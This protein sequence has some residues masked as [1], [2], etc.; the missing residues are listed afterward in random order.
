MNTS[1][2]T[3]SKGGERQ[4]D[5][6]IIKSFATRSEM[7]AFA[8]AEIAQDLRARLDRQERVRMVFA[9]A[10]SQRDVLDALARS[11]GVDWTRVEAFHMDEYVGL[12]ED[13][14]QRFGNWLGRHFFDLVPLAKVHRMM[15]GN[16][17]AATAREY[18]DLLSAAPIDVIQL[19]IGVN[20]HVAFNDPP[21]ARFDD[22]EKVKIV[23]LDNVC[24]QQQV[25]DDCFERFEDV[26]ARAITLT[27][28]C[29]MSAERLFC[30]VPG[31][32]KRAAVK[33]ALEGPITTACPAS[34]LRQHPACTLYLDQDSDPH[35]R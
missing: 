17:P 31:Q 7:G 30:M 11:E 20:G 18:A 16:D 13:A 27:V 24:R 3:S 26:P 35:A 34:I 12:A 5:K 32:T 15:P 22:P 25:D 23:E 29:L 21:V 1:A 8:A 6:L 2:L 28:P 9:A 33:A 4:V 14:P 19:G 10:P